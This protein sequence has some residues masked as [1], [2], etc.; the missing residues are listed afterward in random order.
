MESGDGKR[1]LGLKKKLETYRPSTLAIRP[2][3]VKS[4]H[5][6]VSFSLFFFAAGLSTG[7]RDRQSR[8]ADTYTTPLKGFFVR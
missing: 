2:F 1:W 8:G 6:V 7:N 3:F 4:S 5:R